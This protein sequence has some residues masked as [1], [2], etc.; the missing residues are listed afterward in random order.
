MLRVTVPAGRTFP[1]LADRAVDFLKSELPREGPEP[2]L[3]NETRVPNRSEALPQMKLASRTLRTPL[4]KL[5]VGSRPLWSLLFKM[6]PAFRT[7]R[8]PFFKMKLVSRT[9][10]K[11]LFKSKRA[12]KRLF[13]ARTASIR[14]F[15]ERRRGV[16]SC[17]VTSASAL[18]SPW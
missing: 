3:Q 7:A 16:R 14:L 18:N 10:R 2:S 13:I 4:L 9:L 17:V 11:L 5:K 1:A 12:S 6:K 8:K 15:G